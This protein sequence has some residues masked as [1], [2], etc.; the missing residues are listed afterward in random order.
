MDP[1]DYMHERLVALLI[2]RKTH[3]ER[4]LAQV[5]EGGSRDPYGRAPLL[6]QGAERQRVEEELKHT[7][8]TLAV[9][10]V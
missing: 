9:A 1:Q 3:L 2:G 6:V 8:E 5:N 4:V 7:R 10:G